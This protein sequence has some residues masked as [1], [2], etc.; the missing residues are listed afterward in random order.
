MLSN[1]NFIVKRI[2]ITEE[3]CREIEALNYEVY[4][5]HNILKYIK[6]NDIQLSK[7]LND[8]YHRKYFDFCLKKLLKIESII[9]NYEGR[10]DNLRYDFKVNFDNRMIIWKESLI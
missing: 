1:R 9:N 3:E 8:S 10:K 7:E 2:S 4:H 6:D 5:S